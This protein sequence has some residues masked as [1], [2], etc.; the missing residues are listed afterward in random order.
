MFT[1][2][3]L[4][5]NQTSNTLGLPAYHI[6]PAFPE[7][8]DIVELLDGRLF[9]VS[10][11]TLKAS[12]KLGAVLDVP[13]CIVVAVDRGGGPTLK[14]AEHEERRASF[15]RV[16]FW[17]PDGDLHRECSCSRTPV[18]G[19][20]VDIVQDGQSSGFAFE[21]MELSGIKGFIVRKSRFE[22]PVMAKT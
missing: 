7:V 1:T 6:L 15:V 22:R 9:K 20:H 13:S 11:T 14:E 21:V 12:S 4:V 10:H 5:H 18:I 8:G 2:Q 3:I 16:I 19:D 17:E